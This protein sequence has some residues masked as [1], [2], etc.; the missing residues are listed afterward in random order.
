MSYYT[1][2][3]TVELGIEVFPIDHIT[4]VSGGSCHDDI[5]IF[6]HFL[7]LFYQ[8]SSCS[9]RSLGK[10]LYYFF[11][12]SADYFDFKLDFICVAMLFTSEIRNKF[13]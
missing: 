10:L 5:S 13:E 9:A 7:Q 3:K 11:H 4:I 8:F 2:R 12:K 1:V 6:F